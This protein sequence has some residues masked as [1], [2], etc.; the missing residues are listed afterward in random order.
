MIRM[1]TDIFAESLGMGTSL[2]V[3]MP[4]AAAGIG[5]GGDDAAPAHGDG[6]PVLYLLHGLSDDCTIWERRTSIE[7]YAS[8]KGIAVVMPQVGRSFYCDEALGEAYWTY[9][10]EEL[11]QLLARTFRISTAR[12]DTFVAGLSMGGF[13]AFKLALNHPERFA[14]AASLSGVVDLVALEGLDVHQ[15]HLAERI[16]GG[17]RPDG[18]QDDLVGLLRA[19]DPESLPALFLDCG[20]EDP[21]VMLNRGFIAA[22]E[23]K[24]VA[25]QSRLRP[26]NHT[27]DFWDTSIQDVLDWLPIR[28]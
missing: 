17:K 23:E 6:V 19:A 26:G 8:E 13:G 1:R 28:A 3:L 11:P 12:E 14:A 10:S 24:G 7:R 18:T 25:M 4:Q 16:W 15:G 2:T 5:M 9:L 20:T 22:A 27:W 21:L